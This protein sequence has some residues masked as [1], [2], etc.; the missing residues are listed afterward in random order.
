M[1][2]RKIKIVVSKND[3]ILEGRVNDYDLR[4]AKEVPIEDIEFEFGAINF[5]NS[6]QDQQ[7][8]T[9]GDN[10]VTTSQ[11]SLTKIA[12]AAGDCGY[13]CKKWNGSEQ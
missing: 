7:F 11:K 8:I 2:K 5:D 9:R 1:S 3:P 10:S 13:S 4:P 12:E 6:R